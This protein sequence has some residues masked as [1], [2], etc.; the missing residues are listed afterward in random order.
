MS[1]ITE[2]VGCY[3][4]RG[5]D[6]NASRNH[7]PR[8]EP[9]KDTTAVKTRRF[10]QFFYPFELDSYSFAYIRQCMSHANRDQN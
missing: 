3:D 10:Y 2:D 9:P 7:S 1:T 8:V 4:Q 5:C 6:D